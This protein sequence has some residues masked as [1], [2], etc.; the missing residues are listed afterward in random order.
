MFL[1]L[2]FVLRNEKLHVEEKGIICVCVALFS[3]LGLRREAIVGG[4]SES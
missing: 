3:Q 4:K 1:I 2:G